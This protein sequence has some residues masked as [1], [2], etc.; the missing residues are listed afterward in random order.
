M[1]SRFKLFITILIGTMVLSAWPA[2]NPKAKAAIW[3]KDLLTNGGFESSP[4]NT[5]WWQSENF[6]QCAGDCIINTSSSTHGGSYQATLGGSVS[7]L[8]GLIYPSQPFDNVGFNLPAD[9]DQITLYWYYKLTTNDAA[10]NDTL[11]VYLVKKDWSLPY[12]AKVFYSAI[13]DTD[14]W[15][16]ESIDLTPYK[17][18][19]AKLYFFLANS[20]AD[21]TTVMI[22]DVSVIARYD[23]TAGPNGA[24]SIN[25]GA[26]GTTKL[27]VT[28]T[29]SPT[30]NASGVEMMRLSNNRKKWTNWLPYSSTYR[31][32]L[33]K[34][35]YGGNK[36]K[37]T[38]RVYVQ[39]K[40][41]LGN[42]SSVVSDTIIYD[43]YKPTGS[44]RINNNAKSTT[45]KAVTLKLRGRDKGSGVKWMRFSNN[46]RS[47]SYWIPYSRSYC[48]WS[49]TGSKGKK[50]V[51]V[52]FMDGAGL[53]S[54]KYRDSIRYK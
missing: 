32:D 42:N 28:L 19:D 25:A 18:N 47:W 26:S 54:K 15:Q 1:D 30:D 37:G 39:F 27:R 44:I 45:S 29:M 33:G 13:N 5:N 51:Y 35:T 36:R 8:N 24:V 22:D 2:N 11:I 21:P 6:S 12:T 4:H 31:W 20:M 46:G 53:K 14:S 10:P 43:V 41:T 16:V 40:D 52:Q 49:L 3:Y 50:Y 17:G 48:C 7:T 23:D 9:A 34:G 38:K